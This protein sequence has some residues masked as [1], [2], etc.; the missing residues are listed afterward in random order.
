MKTRTTVAMSLAVLGILALALAPPAQAALL[1]YEGFD[2][3][4]VAGGANLHG[5]A[6][7]SSVGLAGT[8]RVTKNGTQEV[9]FESDTLTFGSGLTELITAPGRAVFNSDSTN[10]YTGYVRADRAFSIT[11]P[12]A[13]STLYGS[14]LFR[15][16]QRIPDI[17]RYEP[18]YFHGKGTTTERYNLQTGPI[19]WQTNRGVLNPRQNYGAGL[20]NG[21]NL[22]GTG[23][24]NPAAGVMGPTLMALYQV[25]G[26][27]GT[28]GT[29]VSASMWVLTS[30]QF[31]NFKGATGGLDASVLNAASTGTG[32]TQVMQKGTISNADPTA[33][34]LLL[35][36]ELFGYRAERGGTSS[37]GD[38][39]W[40][41]ID[42]MRLG[43][44]GLN[45]VTPVVPEP[46]SIVLLLAGVAGLLLVRRRR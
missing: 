2:V 4:G 35:D 40:M 43:L 10:S 5:L 26:I 45:A 41:A 13:G 6:G 11:N 22:S 17:G 44:V 39:G 25:E 3:S 38:G 1:V 33:W 28:S 37:H 15:I 21:L 7:A 30:D 36:G 18:W 42:E 23:Y 19:G 29:P 12:D 9:T 31:D 16:E 24:P 27:N 14:Y 20:T 34:P 8:W 32:S 46:S